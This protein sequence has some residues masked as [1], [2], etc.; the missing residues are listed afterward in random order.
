MFGDNP[1]LPKPRFY[2]EC[3]DASDKR[4]IFVVGDIHGCFDL[5]DTRLS[6]L[7][8]D[9]QQDLLVS[10]GDLVDRGPD[11]IG[12]E[13]YIDEPWFKRVLGNHEVIA[14]L[15]GWYCHLQNG[16]SWLWH[17]I[18]TEQ[19][20]SEIKRILL[21]LQDAPI[22]LQVITPTG[23]ILGFTHAGVPCQPPRTWQKVMETACLDKY[24]QDQL[25][26]DRTTIQTAKQKP[27]AKPLIVEGVDWCFAGHT[28]VKQVVVGGNQVWL[29]TGAFATNVLTV[30]EV[31]DGYVHPIDR[32]A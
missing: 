18:Q 3:F 20:S 1:S 2:T 5:L 31:T 32:N 15:E 9:K 28:P 7:G 23:K 19:G 27:H 26:W 11:S 30:L 29:D 10:V 12:F 13:R 14:Q 8:F 24:L 21:R 16:G 22:A 4:K 25:L 6:I 17:D